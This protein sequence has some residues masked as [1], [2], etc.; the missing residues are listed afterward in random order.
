[1]VSTAEPGTEPVT[2]RAMFIQELRARREQAGLLQRDFAGKAHVSL[3]SVKQY[4]AGK[5]KPGRTFAIWCD[6][7]YGCPGTFERLYDGMIAESHPPW[8]GPRGPSGRQSGM[9]A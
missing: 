8:F 3:S 9:R 1:V 5:K 7:F 4:E 2:F 6:H